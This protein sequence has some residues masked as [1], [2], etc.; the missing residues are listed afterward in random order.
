M[1]P[2]RRFRAATPAEYL[3]RGRSIGA[4]VGR[5]ANR[6]GGAR[7]VLDGQS[8]A[9]DANFLGRRMLHGDS[10]G[11]DTMLWLIS[12]LEPASVT[13]CLS[14]PDGLWAFRAA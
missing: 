8:H 1:S 6:I 4:I 10:E 7:V 12:A 13:L 3:G 2:I 14:L 5:Y 11:T 9:L